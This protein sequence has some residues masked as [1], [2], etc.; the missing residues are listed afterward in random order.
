MGRGKY[1]QIIWDWNG[2]LLDDVDLV[3]ENDAF[4]L[5]GNF[6][7][8][9]GLG[10]HYAWGKLEAGKRCLASLG[11]KKGEGVLLSGIRPTILRWRRP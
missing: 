11:L 3:I 2:T 4:A 8:V 5:G 10:D 1:K 7:A 6:Q 9:N